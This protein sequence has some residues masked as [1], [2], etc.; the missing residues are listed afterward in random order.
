MKKLK[1]YNQKVSV[2]GRIKCRKI[3]SIVNDFYGINCLEPSKKREIVAPRQVAIYYSH[4]LTNLT[5]SS[6][7]LMF[8]KDHATVLHSI[9][10][11]EGRMRFDKEFKKQRPE[12]EELIFGVNFKTNDE[13][14]LF[15]AKEDL[16]E[17]INKMSLKQCNELKDIIIGANEEIETVEN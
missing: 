2:M 3:I 7:G 17:L 14:I 13:F 1:R 4:K 9:D 15:T 6:V 5:L 16:N 11:V 12:L 8:N 10:I